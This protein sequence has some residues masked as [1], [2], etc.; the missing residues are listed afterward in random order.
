MTIFDRWG[1]KIYATDNYDKPWDGTA[2]EG[3]EAAQ[4]DVYVYHIVV[5][6]PKRVKHT[7]MGTVTLV[8]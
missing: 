2:N 4:M 8:R 1:N 5:K 7:Y 6:D 3:K